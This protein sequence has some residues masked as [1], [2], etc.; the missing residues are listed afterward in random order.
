[1]PMSEYYRGLRE[2]IGPE[3]L[4]IPS[5]AAVIRNEEDEILFIRKPGETLWGL[6]AGTIEPGEKPSRSIRR[7]VYEETGLMVNPNR[8]IGVFGG[9]KFRFEYNNGHQVEYL[10]MVFEC[11]MIN[12][13]LVGLDGE[14]EELKFFKEEELPELAIPYPKEIFA[15]NSSS[16][17]PIFE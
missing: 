9:E 12:R 16:L 14:A 8:M 10:A 6:P 3:L 11:S 15:K 5:V 17:K 2:K 1:M 4:L 13:T 7:E